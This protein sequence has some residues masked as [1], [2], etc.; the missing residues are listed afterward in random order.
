MSFGSFFKAVG[1]AGGGAIFSWAQ[2]RHGATLL[3]GNNL[4]FFFLGC[5]SFITALLTFEP[6][7]PASTDHP[8]I[9]EF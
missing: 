3:P 4:V 2:S 6:F 9:E 5:V 7:L 1:P 8:F